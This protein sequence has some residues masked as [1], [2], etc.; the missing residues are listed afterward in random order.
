MMGEEEK[1]EEE[2]EMVG[3]GCV[4][5]KGVRVTVAEGTWRG[6]LDL[7][8]GQRE[9][10]DEWERVVAGLF[11]HINTRVI[12]IPVEKVWQTML[13]PHSHAHSRRTD[14]KEE[15][16]GEEEVARKLGVLKVLWLHSKTHPF[17][18]S[19]YDWKTP[20]G[21]TTARWE[22]PIEEA[23]EAVEGKLERAE[24][25][26]RE[27]NV[28]DRKLTTGEVEV[29]GGAEEEEEEEWYD[30][31]DEEE[32]ETLASAIC[33]VDSYLL[34]SIDLRGFVG[35]GWE[36]E[37]VHSSVLRVLIQRFDQVAAFV[38]LSILSL[39][40]RE[41]RV[42]MVSKAVMV[43][44]ALAEMGNFHSSMAILSC[45]VGRSSISRLTKT[46]RAL[47]RPS[48]IRLEQLQALMAMD[49]NFGAYRKTLA[50]R[51]ANKLPTVPFLGCHIHDL[52]IIDETMSDYTTGEFLNMQKLLQTGDVVSTLRACQREVFSPQTPRSL[53]RSVITFVLTMGRESS[54]SITEEHQISQLREPREVDGHPSE[55]PVRQ[56]HG[57]MEDDESVLM[58][59]FAETWVDGESLLH[60]TRANHDHVRGTL[61]VTSHH[62]YFYASTLGVSS[63]LAIPF[64]DI[65]S[66]KTPSGLFGRSKLVLDLSSTAGSRHPH[67][68]F[69]NILKRKHVISALRHGRRACAAAE[70][71]QQR[72]KAVKDRIRI[73]SPYR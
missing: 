42:R 12:P 48:L 13:A 47:P 73:S 11:L 37:S 70:I 69:G 14:N 27:G 44:S 1:E 59:L 45:L 50:E 20:F 2:E 33:L 22:G 28:Y 6:V 34:A 21:E 67:V 40:R 23:V 19:R 16:E 66:I 5:P 29:G 68:K 57:S 64:P 72:V 54:L 10:V 41:D 35:M 4:L 32:P 60:S 26:A 7:V 71:V 56:S 18:L 65:A 8:C 51:L 39:P 24:R 31:W 53:H 63:H 62:V 52:A 61:C 55:S 17:D 9:R 15:E 3:R 46:F 58:A 49:S 38:A 43:A 25:R 30:V 36:R